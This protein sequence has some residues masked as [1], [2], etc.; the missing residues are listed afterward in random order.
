MELYPSSRSA[1]HHTLLAHVDDVHN[2]YVEE[3]GWRQASTIQGT[4]EERSVIDS[5][6]RDREQQINR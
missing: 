6:L 3:Q 4:D 1:A 5:I 2:I